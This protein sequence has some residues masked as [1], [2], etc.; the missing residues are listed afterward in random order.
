MKRFLILM[1]ALLM[2]AAMFVAC[3]E[4]GVDN[5]DVSGEG[6]VTDAPET[7]G[8]AGGDAAVSVVICENKE[9]QYTIIYPDGSEDDVVSRSKQIA[10]K[11]TDLGGKMRASN[12][13]TRNVEATAANYEILVGNTNRPET[14]EVMN[15]IGYDDYAIRV[16]GNKIV[17]TAH[18]ADRLYEAI[19]YFCANSL[20]GET[21]DGKAVVSY[22]ADYQF[23]GDRQYFINHDN[24][25]E[26]YRIVSTSDSNMVA[27]AKSFAEAIEK[28]YGIKL[29]VV[30]DST[31]AVEREIVI[32]DTNRDICKK[33][34]KADSPFTYVVK[35]EGKTLLIGAKERAANNYVVRTVIA[36]YVIDNYDN[37]FNFPAGYELSGT[38]GDFKNSAELAEGADIR[39]FSFNVLFNTEVKDPT[40]AERSVA[41]GAIL[42]YFAPEVVGLQEINADWYKVLDNLL[43]NGLYKIT[44]KKT[45]NG[46]TN[47]TTIIYNTEK[48][49]LLDHGV[50]TYAKGSNAQIRVASWAYFEC[51]DDGKKFVV[52]NT[53][54]DIST[55][56]DNVI[57][58][59]KEMGELCIKLGEQY[60]CPVITTGDYNKYENTEAYK[61]FIEV[62]GYH[63]AK[64]TAKVIERAHGTYHSPNPLGKMPNTKT[65]ESIDH[66]FG[67]PDA[68][69]MF[70]TILVDQIVLDSSDHCPIF[71]DVKLK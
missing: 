2:I 65:K 62:S 35:A 22:V 51:L 13:W 47:Y 45:E 10:Q 33:Y 39:V 8:N 16:V 29:E 20:K 36:D 28:E 19:D 38:I 23:K 5:P 37:T 52:V 57:P 63:E 40:P 12:D 71:A 66:I 54:W 4:G 64:Y 50:K 56:E 24:P 30:T 26:G 41:L 17:V 53:H 27:N 58:Q 44:D 6:E 31:P 21:V 14:L 55:Y 15:S 18:V 70:F 1:L 25:L 32:G 11:I 49:K 60:G 68:E 61:K 67:S 69:F 3:D 34:M 46:K 48:V 59:A 7:E 9:T 43:A 42:D